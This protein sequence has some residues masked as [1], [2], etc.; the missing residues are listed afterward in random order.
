[1]TAAPPSMMQEESAIY[2]LSAGM[3]ASDAMDRRPGLEKAPAA[4]LSRNRDQNT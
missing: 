1:M 3:C 2:A 4:G